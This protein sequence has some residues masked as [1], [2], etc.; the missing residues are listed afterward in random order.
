MQIDQQLWLKFAS[1]VGLFAMYF[2]L[3]YLHL[4]SPDG[5][6]LTIVAALT[7]L[8]IIHKNDIQAARTKTDNQQS[9]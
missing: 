6:V 9:S 8:G 5:L 2:V 3:V 1:G 4:A 7:A